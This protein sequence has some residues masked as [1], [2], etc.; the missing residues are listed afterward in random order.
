MVNS[1]DLAR[2]GDAA[3]AKRNQV[4]SARLLTC[5]IEDPWLL[6]LAHPA[7]RRCSCRAP[8]PRTRSP[9]RSSWISRSGDSVYIFSLVARPL[10]LQTKNLQPS[11][12]SRAASSLPPRRVR[13]SRF[14]ISSWRLLAPERDAAVR[15]VPALQLGGQREFCS[16]PAF[17]DPAGRWQH[18]RTVGTTELYIV[19]DHLVSALWISNPF[20]ISSWKH[21]LEVQ[22]CE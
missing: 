2:P 17:E 7:L 15:R 22:G 1:I 14:A 11:V 21:S 9:T 5:P 8:L 6:N 19:E 13:R 20:K 4:R 18:R 16:D 3:S 12:A 10:M